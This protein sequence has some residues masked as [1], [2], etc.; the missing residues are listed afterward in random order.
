MRLD[1]QARPSR[2]LPAHS[3]PRV[4]LISPYTD[5]NEFLLAQAGND[6]PNWTFDVIQQA[7]TYQEP[8]L[9]VGQREN[10]LPE[11]LLVVSFGGVLATFQ[12]TLPDY[13]ALQELRRTTYLELLRKC[14]VQVEQGGGP[15]NGFVG[16]SS[17]PLLTAPE[18]SRKIGREIEQ[19]YFESLSEAEKGLPRSP[20]EVMD[21]VECSAYAAWCQ[22]R[23]VMYLKLKKQYA[24]ELRGDRFYDQNWS[25][26]LDLL[27]LSRYHRDILEDLRGVLRATQRNF[28]FF[29]V[30]RND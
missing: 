5:L 13:R 14:L 26:R 10:G 21:I 1:E 27:N 11:P 22:S 15:P 9:D 17:E 3:S 12:R 8:F 30:Q 23:K 20:V 2:P 29:E 25:I 19:A 4:V 7:D 24:E 18:I 6:L 28:V 16:S